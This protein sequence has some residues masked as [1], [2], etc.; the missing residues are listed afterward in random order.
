MRCLPGRLGVTRI[1]QWKKAVVLSSE[2]AWNQKTGFAFAVFDVKSGLFL[3]G[4]ELNR[5]NRRNNFANLGYWV[6]SSQSGGGIWL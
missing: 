6:R 3:G 1:I 4:V 2:T 5:I